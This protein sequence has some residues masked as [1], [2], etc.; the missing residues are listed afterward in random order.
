MPRAACMSTHARVVACAAVS[1]PCLALA[2]PHERA[3]IWLSGTGGG[4]Q[5]LKASPVYVQAVQL[6]GAIEQQ[7]L[8]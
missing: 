3:H 6:H 2:A 4:L 5:L 7:P 1:Q 8:H